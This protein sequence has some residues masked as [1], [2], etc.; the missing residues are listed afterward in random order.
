VKLGDRVESWTD[1]IAAFMEYTEDYPSPEAFRLWS[2]IAMV[3]GALERR[4]WTRTDRGLTYGNLY[5]ML[6][7][8]PSVG[9][10]IIE[11]VR[12]LWGEAIDPDTHQAAFKVAPDSV[13][14]ASLVDKLA[15]CTTCKMPLAAGGKVLEYS[16]LL[17]AAEEIGVL[18]P[19]YD[20]EFVGFLNGIW[21]NKAIHEETRRHGPAKALLIKR[22]QLTLLMGVQPGWMQTV[23]PE[24][25]W[26]TGL[27]ARI[28][29][30][31]ASAGPYK[32][33]FGGKNHERD[34]KA[35][36]QVIAGLSEL[37]GLFGE[38]RWE[39]DA[40]ER[41]QTWDAAGG[42]PTPSHSK[43]THYNGRRT[44]QV[45]KLSM[46]AH[47]ARTGKCDGITLAD[48]DRAIGW[49]LLAESTM[50]DI[51]RAMIGKSDIEVIR[52]LHLYM[53]SMYNMGKQ[54]PISERLL[55]AFLA[56]RLPSDKVP[57]VLETAER[58]GFITRELGTTDYVP[59]GVD[60]GVE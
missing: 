57:R 60:R 25:A 54:K 50:P 43:L 12:D 32:P 28:I 52:E 31:Y 2:A 7:A 5:L 33:L 26:S 47:V 17:V 27:T 39:V 14:K 11:V 23:L 48:V 3:G 44:A 41:L 6:V 24:E 29:M 16:S 13:T 15:S 36:K 10:F 18:M 53:T 59:R 56:E 49:L 55:F 22:P 35:R 1:P 42:P 45:L 19:Q 8:P 9:K 40:A 21:N 20:M 37:A 4:V 46:I 58:S 38:C 34:A 30:V 51:F